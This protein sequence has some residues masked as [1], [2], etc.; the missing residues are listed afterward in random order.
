MVS[1]LEILLTVMS[2]RWAQKGEKE[3]E[4]EA[5]ALAKAAAPY[6]HGRPGSKGVVDLAGVADGELE[7]LAGGAGAAAEGE[8]EPG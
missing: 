7:R 1:P 8:G 6:V 5:V 2:E 3:A 4:K